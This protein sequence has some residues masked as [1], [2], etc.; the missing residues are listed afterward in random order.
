MQKRIKSLF[1]KKFELSVH[2]NFIFSNN[3]SST[4]DYKC[5]KYIFTL[6]KRRVCYKAQFSAARCSTPRYTR[7]INTST[8][9]PEQLYVHPK[10]P[11]RVSLFRKELNLTRIQ[12]ENNSAREAEINV[13]PEDV[14][15]NI[16]LSSPP[17][18]ELTPA[19]AANLDAGA[20]ELSARRARVH[21]GY[22]GSTLVNR[23]LPL[24][25]TSPAR[26]NRGYMRQH[27][28]TDIG[29][30]VEVD[31]PGRCVSYTRQRRCIR[32]FYIRAVCGAFERCVCGDRAAFLSDVCFRRAKRK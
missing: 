6:L 26:K 12:R 9:Q 15:D 21:R 16:L 23:P 29:I 28:S 1:V 18:R 14:A 3:P 19:S 11:S 24:G 4:K 31:S 8:L 30:Y 2:L 27:P 25:R 22:E 20:L 10:T 17:P 5:A 13:R 7:A 32:G